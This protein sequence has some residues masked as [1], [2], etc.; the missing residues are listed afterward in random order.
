MS[1]LSYTFSTKLR[2]SKQLFDQFYLRQVVSFEN[3]DS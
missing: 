1:H 2:K 3:F